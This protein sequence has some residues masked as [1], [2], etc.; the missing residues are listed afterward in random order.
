MDDN[1]KNP[2]PD[3][4]KDDDKQTPNPTPSGGNNGDPGKD[5]EIEVDDWWDDDDDGGD[6]DGKDKTPA[7]KP[8]KDDDDGGGDDD[9]EKT[10]HRNVDKKLDEQTRKTEQRLSVMEQ[11]STMSDFLNS[12]EGEMYR[13]FRDKLNKAIESGKLVGARTSS[14]LLGMALG[15]D[16]IAKIAAKEAQKANNKSRMHSRGGNNPSPTNRP[17]RNDD[18][19]LRDIDT[20]INGAPTAREIMKMDPLSPEFAAF[21]K[22]VTRNVY[23]TK[24]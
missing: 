11:K 8:K 10:I 6:D 4:K 19:D 9:I 22:D 7:P 5:D 12:D 23:K 15:A 16:T 18:G 14:Q 17:V 21:I 3:S 2:T 20:S 24:A 1:G 13:P